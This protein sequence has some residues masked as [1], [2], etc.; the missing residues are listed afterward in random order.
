MKP[1]FLLMTICMLATPL[2]AGENTIDSADHRF[3]VETDETPDFQRHVVP[4]LGKLGCNGRA[5]HGSFQGRGGFQLSLFGYDF[6]SDHEALLERLDLDAPGESLMIEKPLMI[7]QHEGG[8]RFKENTWQ[9]R[10]LTEW[11][12][13]GAKPVAKDA[14]TLVELRVTPEEILFRNDG[15]TQQLNVVA[16]W[17]DGSEEDV[18]PL[19]VFKT[20]DDQ[21]ADITRD[22]LVTAGTAGDS[23]VVVS[24]DRAVVPVP[25]IRPVTEKFGANYPGMKTRTAIDGLVVNKLSKLGIIPSEVCTDAEFLRRVCLDLT[26][27]LPTAKEV[28]A[29]LADPSSGKRSAKVN[30]LLKRP[31][32]VAWWTTKLCDFTGNSDDALN[33]VTP[34]N[35]QASKDWYNWIYSRVEQNVAYDKLVEG[36]VVATSREDDESY[37]DFCSTMSGM[38]RKGAEASFADRETMPDYWARRNFRKPEERAIGFAYTF[39]GTRIQC[40]QCHKHPFDQWTQ[41]D[42]KQFQNVFTRTQFGRNP[43]SREEY[44]SMMASLETKDLK[45][46]ELRRKI[47]E[48]ARE[49]KTVPFQ[50][51]F[52]IA[53]RPEIKLPKKPDFDRIKNP[54][55]RRK[56]EQQYAQRL[57]RL[58]QTNKRRRGGAVA[59]S[60][61][62]LGGDVLNLNEFEDPRKPL[63]EWLRAEPKFAKAFVNRVWAN[64]FNRGIVEPADDMSL[65]NPPVNAELL[66]YLATGFVENRFDMKWLHREIT[67]SDTYQRSWRA[68]E[69]NGLDERNFS[70]S[71]PRRLPA[72]VAVDAI[73]QATGSDTTAEKRV[74]SNDG[75]AIAIPG[76]GRRIRNNQSYYA[77]TIFGRSIRESNCDCDRSMEPSLLQTVFLRNDQQTLALID[78]RDS[79]LADVAKEAGVQFTPKQVPGA[80]RN[81]ASQRLRRQLSQQY[82]ALKKLKSDDA[83]P[84]QLKKVQQRIAQLRTRLGMSSPAKAVAKRKGQEDVTKLTDADAERLI[85]DAYLR[86][87]SRV[88]TDD[89]KAIALTHLSEAKDVV[90]GARDLL[91]ALLNTKE[92]IVN[93]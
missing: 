41:D 72:E 25:V 75:R 32:Y 59:S 85:R 92:F 24:Y 45:G 21:V 38:Y 37:E 48:L 71:V 51:V 35:G 39:L 78:R 69:T 31:G 34:V 67:S 22:G 68:N 77:L 36:L 82:K 93:H 19:C 33:N 74:A 61:K 3:S 28:E 40:A 63:M 42:F 8:R 86:T 16:V 14:A 4:L 91:W 58:K 90:A 54:K 66:D 23:H 20:N 15:Q 44:N 30:E 18:T 55:Q 12:A 29:F 9:H 80:N 17:T 65:A 52:A 13:R 81:G 27:T 88:P 89:E 47:G 87:L 73:T 53:P 83:S 56:A 2:V 43:A 7:Q 50:E 5:C 64:Y 11:I 26:G 70:R 10:L 60:G 46:G 62:L 84:K 6:K 1:T 49:G 79:W 57:K 76:A